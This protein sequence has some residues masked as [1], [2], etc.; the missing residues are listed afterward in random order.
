MNGLIICN[1]AKKSFTINSNNYNQ[2]IYFPG[3]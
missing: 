1:R 3:S 2:I